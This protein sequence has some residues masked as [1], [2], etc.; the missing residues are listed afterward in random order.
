MI[1]FLKHL[2]NIIKNYNLVFK[3]CEYLGYNINDIIEWAK[4]FKTSE[5]RMD[6]IIVNGIT[7][8]DDSYNASYESVIGGLDYIKGYNRK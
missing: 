6:T 3:V 7:I 5:S 4:D 8:I 2:L 1:M